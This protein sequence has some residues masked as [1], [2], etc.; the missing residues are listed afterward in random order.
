[1]ADEVGGPTDHYRVLGVAPAAPIDEVRRAYLSLAQRFH[2]DR[3]GASASP[4][5]V[6]AAEARMSEINEAWAVLRDPAA[7]ATYDAARAAARS[8]RPT[9]PA[10]ARSSGAAP[11]A[12][13]PPRMASRTRIPRALFWAPFVV[14]VLGAILLVAAVAGRGGAPSDPYVVGA[15]VAVVN[16]DG[17]PVRLGQDSSTLR[18]VVV[19]CA[20]EHTGRI[21]RRPPHGQPC[22]S[23][24]HEIDVPDDPSPICID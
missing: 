18:V 15:C 9:A 17:S 4:A 10:S 14:L 1:M 21:D 19:D 16:V 23:T 24:D 2:P 3:A 7:R 12:T 8:A 6:A 5:A 11:R 22:P 13:A 20:D